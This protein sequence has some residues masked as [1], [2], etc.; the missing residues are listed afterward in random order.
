M[1]AKTIPITSNGEANQL[2]IENP[3][4]L[5]VGKLLDQHIG[6]TCARSI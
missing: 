6:Q 4:A 3:L 2:L 5:V 1:A